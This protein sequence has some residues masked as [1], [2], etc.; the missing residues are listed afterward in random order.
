M[1]RSAMGIIVA[2]LAML[3]SLEASQRQIWAEEPDPQ[4]ISRI[5]RLSGLFDV[6]DSAELEGKPWVELGTGPYNAAERHEGWLLEQA[7][8]FVSIRTFQGELKRFPVPPSGA[9][10]PRIHYDL[11]Q[12]LVDEQ[13]EKADYRLAWLVIPSNVQNR[14]S[15]VLRIERR[16]AAHMRRADGVL[17]IARYAYILLTQ[18]D[19]EQAI[20]MYQF[21][22]ETYPRYLKRLGVTGEQ[23]SNLNQFVGTHYAR[24]LRNDALAQRSEEITDE[25]MLER[26]LRISRVPDNVDYEHVVSL[27]EGYVLLAGDRDPFESVVEVPDMKGWSKSQ[28]AEFWVS[29]IHRQPW[30]ND[31]M[32]DTQKSMN[33]IVQL[34]EL[35][36]AAL[37]AIVGRMDDIRPMKI[38]TY[39]IRH[40]E[41]G[42]WPMRCS[43]G[44][45]RLFE[46]ITGHSLYSRE[47]KIGYPS[48]DGMVPICRDNAQRWLE[49]KRGRSNLSASSSQP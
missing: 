47:G 18:G 31:G 5:Q 14:A 48:Y 4:V 39:W 37:P 10:R 12:E 17:E 29:V 24:T 34:K 15:S 43:D 44:C 1:N 19:L 28:Q 30:P 20:E 36:R 9:E 33:G 40:N 46:E 22:E 26:W 11:Q 21:A 42:Y 49:N 27:V 3:V 23:Y 2:M 35:G 8:G 16:K 38:T 32:T 25:Q 7:A 45:V 6:A 13:L 41:M